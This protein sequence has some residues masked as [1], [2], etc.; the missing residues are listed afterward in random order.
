MHRGR[1]GGKYPHSSRRRC[2]R[3]LCAPES[4]GGRPKAHTHRIAPPHFHTLSRS[5]PCT[6]QLHPAR[7]VHQHHI[8]PSDQGDL[9]EAESWHG[10]FRRSCCSGLW[11]WVI[12][13]GHFPM[14]NGY[15]K[16]D[17]ILYENVWGDTP[18]W[19][20]I[21]VSTQ[22][23]DQPGGSNTGCSFFY[24]LNGTLCPTQVRRARVPCQRLWSVRAGRRGTDAPRRAAARTRDEFDTEKCHNVQRGALARDPALQCE[25]AVHW[26]GAWTARMRRWL[27]LDQCVQVF[28]DVSITSATNWPSGMMLLLLLAMVA[29]RMSPRWCCCCCCCRRR[30]LVRRDCW[31]DR[32][33]RDAVDYIMLQLCERQ[34]RRR[35]A[36]RGTTRVSGA[37]DA[38]AC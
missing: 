26:M 22:Q 33:Q 9:R 15:G 34:R 36:S 11:S 29:C 32:A 31:R 13:S 7:Q 19:W 16:I 21:Y 5:C 3:G 17:S 27:A 8:R 10:T 37:Q 4:A 23:Q 25:R 1:P 20:S 14:Q 12:S 6:D 24:P 30:F 18:L 2:E 28:E 35:C 38:R